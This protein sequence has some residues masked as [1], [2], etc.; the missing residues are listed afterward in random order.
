MTVYK[1]IVWCHS[2]N[3]APY[4]LRDVSFDKSVP[5]FENPENLPTLIEL[6]DLMDSA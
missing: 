1:N 2:E 4:H 3:N 5:Q 6:D